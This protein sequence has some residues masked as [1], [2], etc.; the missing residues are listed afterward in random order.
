MQQNYGGR[1]GE[2]IIKNDD[3]SFFFI[4]KIFDELTGWQTALC[5]HIFCHFGI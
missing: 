2:K 1:N 5:N 4:G 3:F